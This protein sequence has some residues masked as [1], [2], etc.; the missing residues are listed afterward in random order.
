MSIQNVKVLVLDASWQPMQI[1]DWQRAF[2]L[3]AENK[4]EVIKN[5]I[6]KFVHSARETFNIPSVIRFIKK[7]TKKQ[8]KVKFSRDNV[9]LRDKATC[10]YCGKKNI[11]REEFTIDHIK[12]RSQ[13]GIS[14]FE[15]CCVC[16]EKC[17]RFKANM[18]PEQAGMR[19]LNKP[20]KPRNTF[21]AFTW[22]KSFP[23]DWR[24]FLKSVEYW[25]DE[26]ETK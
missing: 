4:V 9:Y 22:I 6:D 14:S 18:T 26:L 15:N 17:N 2:V 12:P 19:L 11:S 8:R 7:I 24:D 3:L 10:Q 1:I 16:C 25:D 13:G 20:I 21:Q 23:L 5:Y